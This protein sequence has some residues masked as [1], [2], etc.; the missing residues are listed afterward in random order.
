MTVIASTIAYS[1]SLCFLPI[2]VPSAVRLG[3]LSSALL[4][5]CQ[6]AEGLWRP[7]P[8]VTGLLR[9]GLFSGV[10]MVLRVP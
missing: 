8:E 9:L 4:E 1:E 7:A 5:G 10:S 6:A 3:N 2:A